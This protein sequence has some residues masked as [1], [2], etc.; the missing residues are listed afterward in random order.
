MAI[1][2]FLKANRGDPD[3]AFTPEEYFDKE[4]T[5]IDANLI[6]L[7]Q[8]KIDK[9]FLRHTPTEKKMLAKHIR[10]DVRED[11]TLDMTVLTEAS[12]KLQQVF[13][14]DIRIREG[15]QMNLGLFI[16]GGQLNKHII[17]VTVDEGGNFNAFGYAA[18]TVG[19]DCEIITKVDHQ[20]P[21]S[22]SNQ[23]FACEAGKGSQTVFQGMV[24]V[25]KDSHR[26]QI[27]VENVN[28]N[29]GGGKCHSVPEIV[30]ATD[31]S[32]VNSGTATEPMDQDRIYYLQTRGMSQAAAEALIISAHRNLA[33]DII[34]DPEVKEEIEQLFLS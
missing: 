21:Y 12:Q 29:L 13:I 11:A 10:I 1:Q 9:I 31:S 19:G 8:G 6:E 18:N 34:Q 5:V 17:Q 25:H 24:S 4:F 7:A 27:G 30:N 28:L 22:V 20:G 26:S 3:W 16:K 2:S 33:F 15:G 23:F 14:Y 32:R